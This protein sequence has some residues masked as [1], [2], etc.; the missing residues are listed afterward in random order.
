MRTRLSLVILGGLIGSMLFTGVAAAGE[1]STTTSRA[2][3]VFTTRLTG[4]V[5]VPGPGDPDGRG[6]AVL[7]VDTKDGTICSLLVVRRID[8]ATAAHIHE[9]PPGVAGPIV[10]ELEPP[11]QGVAFGCVSNPDLA[12]AIVENPGN[13]YVNVHNVP[14]P[15]GAVRGDLG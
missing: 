5:E 6:R 1:Q 2:V 4:E 15:A 9:G 13:Y 8:P 3:T 12:A 7:I 11:T 10:Q 14:F